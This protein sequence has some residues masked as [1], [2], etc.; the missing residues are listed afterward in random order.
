MQIE[1]LREFLVL[2]QTLNFHMAA[3]ALFITDSALS[4]HI[5][6]VENEL[7]VPL[8]YRSTRNVEFTPIGHQL[9]LKVSELIKKYDDIHNDISI[10]LAGYSHVFKL[11]LPYYAMSDYLGTAPS[12]FST[13]SPDVA[14]D[15]LQA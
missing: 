15:F 9:Y 14:L 3:E 5:S 6:L 8:F 12:A 1:Y 2:G 13:L 10:Y 11:G 4:R 7:G